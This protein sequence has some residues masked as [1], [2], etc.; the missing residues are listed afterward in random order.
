[1]VSCDGTV[2]SRHPQDISLLSKDKW[3]YSLLR[4]QLPSNFRGILDFLKKK[5]LSTSA[6]AAA[7][8]Y[9]TLQNRVEEAD[10]KEAII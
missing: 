8:V 4:L 5:K 9:R 3:K 2:Q 10:M 1:M 7:A 6:F